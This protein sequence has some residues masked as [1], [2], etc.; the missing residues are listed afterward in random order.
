MDFYH[1]TKCESINHFGNCLRHLVKY[2]DKSMNT[3]WITT[4]FLKIISFL[5]ILIGNTGFVLVRCLNGLLTYNDHWLL[6]CSEVLYLPDKLVLF[7]LFFNFC[8]YSNF[9][10]LCLVGFSFPIS[11]DYIELF[12]QMLSKFFRKIKCRQ[13]FSFKAQIDAFVYLYSVY[14]TEIIALHKNCHLWLLRVDSK[15]FSLAYHLTIPIF[16]TEYSKWSSQPQP[17]TIIVWYQVWIIF[18][19]IF[20]PIYPLIFFR[21]LLLLSMIVWFYSIELGWV[22]CLNAA[23]L[24]QSIKLMSTFPIVINVAL[25]ALDCRQSHDADHECYSVHSHLV[26]NRQADFSPSPDVLTAKIIII[27]ATRKNCHLWRGWKWF[28]TFN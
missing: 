14:N 2:F 17:K 1:D 23:P 26:S 22:W 9:Y 28:L 3:V 4:H 15:N 6:F 12:V 16:I 25:C 10:N 18:M 19:T 20:Y 11:Q 21:C 24:L 27:S 5:L 7:T 8:W 13:L